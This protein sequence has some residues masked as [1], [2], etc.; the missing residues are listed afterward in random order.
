VKKSA[1]LCGAASFLAIA[2]YG[3]AVA[4]QTHILPPLSAARAAYFKAHPQEEAALLARLRAP[5]ENAPATENRVTSRAGGTWTKV[6]AAPANGLCNPLLLTDATVMV[7]SCGTKA[8]FKLTPT[9]TGSYATG[10]WTKLA[11]LP[12]IGGVQYSPQYKASAVLPDGRVIV[13]GGEYNNG[14]EAFTNLGAIYNP[15]TNTWA[16]VAAPSGWTAIGDAAGIVLANNTFMLSS[17]SA[18]PDVDALF[19][20]TTLGW[21]ATG[22][23]LDGTLAYQDEQGYELLPTGQVLTVDVW[24]GYTTQTNPT[25]AELYTPHTGKWTNTGSTPVSL[26]DPYACGNFEIGPAVTRGDGS[27]I[28]FGGNS[29]CT[30]PAV[31]P[32]AIYTTSKATWA[33][34]PNVPSTCG[35]TGKLPCTLADAPAALLPNGNI[36]FAASAGYGDAPTHFFEFTATKTINQVADELDFASSSS[37]FYYNFLVLPT[38]QILSTD[39]SSIAELYTPSGSPTPGLAPVITT[40][41][42]TLTHGTTYTLAGKQIAGRSQGA[43]YGDDEQSATNYP[44]VR[45]TNT[46]T[47]HVFYART[48]NISSS[49]IAPNAIATTTF[50]VPSS[51]ETG[52]STLAVIANGISSTKN[53]VTIN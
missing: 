17:A 41:P 32:T 34:G 46:A 16:A 12:V 20:P 8:W 44:L 5:D 22:A 30:T 29:G 13:E 7:Q 28:A 43:Y 35:T 25:S 40:V 27:V 3:A 19:N 42:T 48:A 14:A 37:S 39:L 1:L 23:P 2:G 4:A 49:S 52:A 18:N 26:V 36:L 31:D 21:T 47:G 6:T 45:I 33:A 9:N 50:T 11:S 10:T 38:G 24:A 53:S 15:L 51:I